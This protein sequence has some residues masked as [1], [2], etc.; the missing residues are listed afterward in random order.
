[1]SCKQTAQQLG[2]APGPEQWGADGQPL[3]R[4]GG[5]CRSKGA[6]RAGSPGA[7][8]A[9][10]VGTGVTGEEVLV[11]AGVVLARGVVVTAQQASAQSRPQTQQAGREPGRLPS[12][13]TPEL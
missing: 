10:V 12:K 11:G 5:A 13:G 2:C 3:H 8:V 6:R 1:M 4:H 9:R 7:V